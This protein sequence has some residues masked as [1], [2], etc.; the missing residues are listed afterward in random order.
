M[1]GGKIKCKYNLIDVKKKYKL[2]Y[3]AMAFIFEHENCII[4]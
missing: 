2:S 1:C 4:T 3:V